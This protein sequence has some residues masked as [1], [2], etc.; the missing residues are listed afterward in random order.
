MTTKT[1]TKLNLDIPPDF[2]DE[3]N[4][5]AK[6]HGKTMKDYV[7]DALMDRLQKDSIEE[8]R[9]W[10][11]MSEAAKKEGVQSN[12]ESENLLMRMKNA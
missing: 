1:P 9:T 3:L 8:G 2:R 11:K 10:G 4:F 7:I 5:Q 6:A 12:L